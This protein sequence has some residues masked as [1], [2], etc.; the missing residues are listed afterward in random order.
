MISSSVK[1]GNSEINQRS[2]FEIS[3]LYDNLVEFLSE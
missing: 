2:H 3:P 1:I